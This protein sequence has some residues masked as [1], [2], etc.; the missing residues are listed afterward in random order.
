MWMKYLSEWIQSS[1]DNALKCIYATRL[2]C[3]FSPAHYDLSVHERSNQHFTIITSVTSTT[4]FFCLECDALVIGLL[5]TTLHLFPLIGDL[6]ICQID[7]G[8]NML[9]DVSL[10]VFRGRF[11]YHRICNYR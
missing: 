5:E 2:S 11:H 4:I 7:N 10:S 3:L 9:E 6:T 1:R 8:D